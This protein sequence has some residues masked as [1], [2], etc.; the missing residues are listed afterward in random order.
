MPW[1]VVAAVAG[2]L[3]V[4]QAMGF[5]VGYWAV[6]KA[7]KALWEREMRDLLEAVERAKVDVLR[8]VRR[9]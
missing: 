1:G 5:A 2:A 4:G 3:V 7:S 8:E 9:R 6:R